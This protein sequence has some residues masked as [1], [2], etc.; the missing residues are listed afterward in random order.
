MM[1]SF[2][3]A[4]RKPARKVTPVRP[5]IEE[6]EHRLTPSAGPRE[7]YMLELINRMRENPAAELQILLNVNDPY[8]AGALAQFGVDTAALANDWLSLAPAPPLAWNDNLA[9]AALAHD[10]VML[11]TDTQDHQIGGEAD[12]G[13]RILNA[14]YA[15]LQ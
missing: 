12:L 1:R 9:A 11:A 4:R 13:T 8:V 6:L 15:S 7:Q 3:N 5:W 2:H 10:Q 14:G